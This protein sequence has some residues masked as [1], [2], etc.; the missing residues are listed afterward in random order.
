MR[1]YTH[2]IQVGI[3]DLD[4]LNHVNNVRYVQWIQDIARAHWI[5][6][7]TEDLLND[8]FWVVL[9]HSIEYKAPAVLYDYINIKTY[10]TKADGVKSTRVVEMFHSETNALLVR[11]ETVWCLMDSKSKR[12]ARINE[13]IRDLFY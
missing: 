3:E 7:A 11:S 4:D 2:T 1:S 5:S 9:Q 6:E 8:Y 12:P 10:V 13:K